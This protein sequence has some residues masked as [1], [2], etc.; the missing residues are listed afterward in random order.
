MG[1]FFITGIDTGCGKTYITGLMAKE[2]KI[3]GVKV[4]TQ[5]L[6]QTGCLGISED[7]LEHRRIMECD[8]FPED[9]NGMT[10]NY[11][12]KFPASPHLA[13]N[14]DCTEIDVALLSENT[15]MLR[16][17]YDV[18]LIEG[19]GGLHVPLTND[20]LTIDYIK[21]QNYPVILVSSSKLGSINHTLLSIESCKTHQV[22]LHGLIYNRLPNDNKIIADD[23]FLIIKKA[24]HTHYNNAKIA[25]IG[26]ENSNK[27]LLNLFKE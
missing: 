23:S 25:E 19:A 2:L 5:K 9:M 6:I 17:K 11:V 26:N 12:F 14:L 15:R 4:I 16:E 13:A 10:C 20:L 8:L 7:I 27:E 1:I 24:L 21:K 22:N 3:S 18:V